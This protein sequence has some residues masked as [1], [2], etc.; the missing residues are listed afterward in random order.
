LHAWNPERQA[1]RAVMA[2]R[3]STPTR[4]RLVM[5]EPVPPCDAVGRRHSPFAARSTTG[6]RGSHRV[7][8]RRVLRGPLSDRRGR[9]RSAPVIIT[10]ALTSCGVAMRRHLVTRMIARR[11]QHRRHLPGPTVVRFDAAGVVP[12]RSGERL[13]AGAAASSGFRPSRE[14]PN[15]LRPSPTVPGYKGGFVLWPSGRQLE[16]RST[17]AS[18]RR[19]GGDQ[20]PWAMIASTGSEHKSRNHAQ[21]GDV[22]LLASGN[23][24]VSCHWQHRRDQYS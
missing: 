22:R 3:A 15:R 6:R 17:W 12:N 21:E 23:A 13:V 19:G 14:V 8:G 16:A 20:G 7:R 1:V 2:L 5:T 4:V 18:G 10:G 11:G 9:G 24:G